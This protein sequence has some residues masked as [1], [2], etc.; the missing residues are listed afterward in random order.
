MSQ[1]LNLSREETDALERLDAELKGGEVKAKADA[2]DLCERYRALRPTL[3]ILVRLVRRIPRVGER[4]AAAIEFLM[5]IADTAC[6][7]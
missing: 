4:I 3:E 1:E 6:P 2:G 7:V 5:G